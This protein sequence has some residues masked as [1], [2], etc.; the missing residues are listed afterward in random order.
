ML[1]WD[2]VDLAIDFEITAD[3]LAGPPLHMDLLEYLRNL[4][5]GYYPSIDGHAIK[6]D[7]ALVEWMISNF[8]TSWPHT[9]NP[10]G[11]IIEPALFG[12]NAGVLAQLIDIL[13][14]R[15]DRRFDQAQQRPHDSY[16]ALLLDAKFR[17][18]RL[19]QESI[20]TPSTLED[21]VAITR[22]EPPR[23]AADLQAWVR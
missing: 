13:N 7:V 5:I 10:V 19:C 17:Q 16:T 4:V 9:E 12:I 11:E 6:P 1:I 2:A 21:L 22:D 20:F 23:S 15:S 3:R 8:R 14:L 18:L